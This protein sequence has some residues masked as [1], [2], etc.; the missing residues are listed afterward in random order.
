[1][2]LCLSWSRF[3]THILHCRVLLRLNVSLKWE[4]ARNWAFYSQASESVK[5]VLLSLMQTVRWSGIMWD[6]FNIP[7]Q[8][9]IVFLARRSADLVN[10]SCSND[11]KSTSFCVKTHAFCLSG[12]QK[13]A[14]SVVLIECP[15]IFFNSLFLKISRT[16]VKWAQ[17]KRNLWFLL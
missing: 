17:W 15:A 1:M 8:Q 3:L 6:Y 14:C 10:C 12:C 7:S 5:A 13:P 11:I 2:R 9:V 16:S 4:K